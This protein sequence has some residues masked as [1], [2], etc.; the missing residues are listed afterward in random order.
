M[1]SPCAEEREGQLTSAS[2]MRGDGQ[3]KVGD[4]G[5]LVMDGAVSRRCDLNGSAKIS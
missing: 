3:C 5:R 1:A 2:S 4:S